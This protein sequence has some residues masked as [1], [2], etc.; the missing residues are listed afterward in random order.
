MPEKKQ[1]KGLGG[2]L[3][4]LQIGLLFNLLFSILEQ[5]M[6]EQSWFWLIFSFF[7]LIIIIFMWSVSK[8]F[9]KMAIIFVW[10]SLV[11]GVIIFIIAGTSNFST[12]PNL[13]NFVNTIVWTIYLIRSKRVK[14]TFVR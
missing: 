6:R 1:L 14:N 9:P 10:G 2:W 11:S 5:F 4:L 13:Y 12:R 3:I 7:T 8:Y